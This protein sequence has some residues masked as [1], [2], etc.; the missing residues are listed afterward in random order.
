MGIRKRER[1]EGR[2]E[3]PVVGISHHAHLALDSSNLLL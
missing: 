2:F 1:G 3:L